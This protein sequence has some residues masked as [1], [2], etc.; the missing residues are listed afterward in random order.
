M[1]SHLVITPT[2]RGRTIIIPIVQTRT[3]QPR[4]GEQLAPLT[5]LIREESGYG[6]REAGWARQL[7]NQTPVTKAPRAQDTDA[8]P[9][10][11]DPW[12]LEV[13]GFQPPHKETEGGAAA[14]Q[15]QA[16]LPGPKCCPPMQ[17]M[18]V[19][20]TPALGGC[21]QPS[22]MHGGRVIRH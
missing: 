7:E 13:P 21:L 6:A 17:T 2:L 4:E 9:A 22:I 16:R 14:S 1:N 19:L 11:H 3:S 20:R 8:K 18:S 12:G 5:L 10:G 15:A